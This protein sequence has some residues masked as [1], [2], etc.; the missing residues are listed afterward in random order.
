MLSALEFRWGT[1]PVNSMFSSFNGETTGPFE[2]LR[3][4]FS[5]YSDKARRAMLGSTDPKGKAQFK[6][7]SDFNPF[8][9]NGG[10][11]QM[12][13]RS[14]VSWYKLGDQVLY[15]MRDSKSLESLLYRAIPESWNY[16]RSPGWEHNG[17]TYQT[18]IWT[19]SMTQARSHVN[20]V[21]QYYSQ[22]LQLIMRQSQSTYG[23]KL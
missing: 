20:I 15:M 13:G 3:G 2:S 8:I 11:E 4:S 7:Y 18:Y 6:D 22:Q 14:N 23:P 19:E 21:D 10:W 9:A 1:G 5:L 17:N 12:I 16:E